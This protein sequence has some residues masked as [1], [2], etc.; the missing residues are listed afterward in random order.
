MPTATKYDVQVRT[1]DLG[2]YGDIAGAMRTASHIR[3][4]GLETAIIPTSGGALRKLMILSPDVPISPDISYSAMQVDVAGHYNDSRTSRDPTQV[5]HMFAEDMDNPENRGYIVPIYIKSG[6]VPKGSQVS[7]QLGGSSQNPMFYR[8]HREWELPEPGKR[9]VKSLLMHATGN[10]NPSGLQ[11]ILKQ[12]DNIA[13]G[14]F[15]PHISPEEFLNSPYVRAL[16]A[17]AENFDGYFALGLFFNQ[18]MEAQ[19]TRLAIQEGYTIFGTNGAIKGNSNKP[20]LIFLGPQPQMM[21]SSLFVSSTMP[22]IVTGDLSLSDAVYAL[23]AMESHGFFYDCPSWKLPTYQEMARI[24]SKG[25]EPAAHAFQEGSMTDSG[26][27]KPADAETVALILGNKNSSEAYR[28]DMKDAVLA[29]IERRF[30][31]AHV[32]IGKDG[33]GLYIP[34]GAPF[35]F[36]DAVESVLHALAN[37]P[38]LLSEVESKRLQLAIG[39]EPVVAI[40]GNVMAPEAPMEVKFDPIE[41]I[42]KGKLKNYLSKESYINPLKSLLSE[43]YLLNK[44]I[45]PEIPLSEENNIGK[46]TPYDPYAAEQEPTKTP[47]GQLDND[48]F[49][50]LLAE[51]DCF[52]WDNVSITLY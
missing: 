40:A 33:Q 41:S 2:G 12:T 43:N 34:R 28:R 22:N 49:A 24:L 11:A 25:Y 20:A 26:R 48:P 6:L 30:G 46:K 23:I 45:I 8:P 39:G 19:I 3:Y 42:I 16:E 44:Y 47:I 29:E 15:K 52:M 5:P 38:E 37:S 1:W 10:N 36:Q 50:Q 4:G 17:A 18:E 13:F 9:D 21:T 35:L 32:N 27:I 7:A 31:M 51:L 14:H